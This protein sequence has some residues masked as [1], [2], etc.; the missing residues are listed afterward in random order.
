[1]A[2]DWT[3]T[4]LLASIKRRAFLPDAGGPFSDV[5]LLALA[6]EVTLSHVVPRIEAAREEYYIATAD[7]SIVASTSEYRIPKR[8]MG[9]VV[10]DVTWIAS[11]GSG[12]SIVYAPL[13]DRDLYGA[14]LAPMSLGPRFAIQGDHVVL[15][16]APSAATGTLRIRYFR[17]PSKLVATTAAARVTGIADAVYTCADVPT[18]ITTSTPLDLV[19]GSP[20]FASIADD[21]TPTA[22]VT[23]T[24][25]TITFAAAITGAAIGDFFAQSGETP[26]QQ[27]PEG[28]RAGLADLV[29]AEV[30]LSLGNSQGMQMRAALGD[31][32]ITKCAGALSP[33][34]HGESKPIVNWSSAL[35]SGAR[36]GRRR[37]L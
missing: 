2:H 28:M 30:L 4:D 6:D 21:R 27:I 37:F 25:G 9:A 3:T 29:A 8:A 22:R 12:A 23:G 24:D 10:R 36:G 13:E 11:D 5:E 34:V 16:P 31:A 26:V 7:Q 33:R 14:S 1:V 19:C 18:A 32:S 20:T 15:L 17:R 35:R